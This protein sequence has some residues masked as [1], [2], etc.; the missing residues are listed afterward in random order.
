MAQPWIQ[1]LG[2]LNVG[3]NVYMIPKKDSYL[4]QLIRNT[5]S[6][7]DAKNT[8]QSPIMKKHIKMAEKEMK[9]KNKY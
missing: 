6:G 7:K 1:A 9:A 5:Y 8:S 4:N 3:S 2:R